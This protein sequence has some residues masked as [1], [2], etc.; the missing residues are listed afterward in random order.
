MTNLLHLPPNVSLS[1]ASKSAPD[2]DVLAGFTGS[3]I[4]TF[5]LPEAKDPIELACELSEI[6]R[7][8]GGEF[9]PRPANTGHRIFLL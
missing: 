6:A 8:L 5:A 9:T 2:S 7:I 4:P 1:D 3:N